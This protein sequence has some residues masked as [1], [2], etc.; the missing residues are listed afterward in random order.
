M[1]YVLLFSLIIAILVLTVGKLVRKKSKVDREFQ[2][3]FECGFST[4]K[5]HRLKFRLHFFLIALV[6]VIFD[7]ELIILFPFFREY[8][9]SKRVSSVVLFIGFLGALTRGLLNE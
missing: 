3:P 5:D 1:L 4:F 8:A 2:S 9:I 6:F 7:V